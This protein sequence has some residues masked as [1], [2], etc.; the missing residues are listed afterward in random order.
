MFIPGK[1]QTFNTDVTVINFE[2]LRIQLPSLESPKYGQ[3]GNEQILRLAFF[4]LLGID[5]TAPGLVATI[6]HD[7]PTDINDILFSSLLLNEEAFAVLK[8]IR[9]IFKNLSD[10]A[11]AVGAHTKTIRDSVDKLFLDPTTP[12]VVSGD[13]ITQRFRVISIGNGATQD[14]PVSF[15]PTT[16]DIYEKMLIQHVSRKTNGS[17]QLQPFAIGGFITSVLSPN[18]TSPVT[19]E[20]TYNADSD[21]KKEQVDLIGRA[22]QGGIHNEYLELK[23]TGAVL[24]A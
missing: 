19:W 15:G 6:V 17:L 20:V 13:N 10:D 14:V 5:I 23:K 9:A 8:I 22:A 12:M 4:E 16:K 18:D 7:A 21:D 2:S 3:V 1:T 11:E 24:A